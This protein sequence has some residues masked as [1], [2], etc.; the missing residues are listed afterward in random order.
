MYHLEVQQYVREKEPK[1]A[2]E[3]SDLVVRFFKLKG[4]EELKY[5]KT[6][7]W[8]RKPTEERR[9]ESRYVSKWTTQQPGRKRYYKGGDTRPPVS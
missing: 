7:A 3:A 9:S 5:V 1:N 2:I 8:T 4:I 6:K